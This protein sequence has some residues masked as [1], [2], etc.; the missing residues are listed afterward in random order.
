MDI[1]D[2][3]PWWETGSV[4]SEI[5]NFRKRYLFQELKENLS[6]RQIDVIV[7]LRRVGKTV[8]MNHL[9]DYLLKN[10]IK[11]IEIMYFSFDLEREELNR[12]I[13]EYE[14]KILRD[15]IRNRRV[16]L[17]F[18]EIHKLKDWE[19]K[20][21]VLYDLNPKVKI[22]LSGSLN[23]MRQSSESLA[24]RAKFHH[25]RP[26]TFREFLEFNGE[27]IPNEGE[28]EIHRRKLDILLNK[29]ILRGFPEA[30]E[31]SDK[32]V[33]EYVRELI[34]ERIIYRD[35]P[36]SFRIEDVE[37]VR[38]LAE[39]ISENPGVILNI[40]SLSRDLGRHKKTV[41][42]AL[43]YLELSFLIKRVSNL[44]SSFLSAS[45]KNKRAYPLHSSLSTSGEESRLIEALIRSEMNAEHYWRKGRY[46]VD[47]VLKGRKVV[48]LEVKNKEK[49]SKNDLKAI[50]KFF[51]IFNV[52]EGYIVC[53]GDEKVV[54]VNGKVIVMP[55]TKFLLMPKIMK[56]T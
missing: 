17:L 26:L 1:V 43:D 51:Y 40:D 9:I 23:L 8:L 48:P 33:K 44:R 2:F 36:E 52:D 56:P 53:K 45:R 35:I 25:L 46:E 14:E 5:L 7:G 19:N 24:G 41:R 50:E 47:F 18:D 12:I 16:Y 55:I 3:N 32:K 38:I 49:L 27:R 29:F 42:N 15:R 54:K 31:M 22:V 34:I 37:I 10:G 20:I 28:F 30:L 21:K 6:E 39:H 4:D 13:K 11:P